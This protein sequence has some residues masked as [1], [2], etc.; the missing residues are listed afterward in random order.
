[1]SSTPLP[2]KVTLFRSLID[3]MKQW[4]TLITIFIEALTANE[5]KKK[6]VFSLGNAAALY[7]LS[8]A[9]EKSID[10]SLICITM[11]KNY[12]NS[13]ITFE[14]NKSENFNFIELPLNE[15]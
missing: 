12:A 10:S 13:C 7:K 9:I 14:I 8:T 2:K 1:M 6:T 3:C 5:E 15:L 11:Y 4:L